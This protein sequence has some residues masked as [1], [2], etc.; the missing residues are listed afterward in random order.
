MTH[1]LCTLLSQ[2]YNIVMYSVYV[3]TVSTV[4]KLSCSQIESHGKLSTPRRRYCVPTPLLNKPLQYYV[5]EIH[6]SRE[7][8]ATCQHANHI[9]RNDF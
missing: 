6:V 2:R 3:Y 9:C 5:L 1:R 8:R 7:L 4:E